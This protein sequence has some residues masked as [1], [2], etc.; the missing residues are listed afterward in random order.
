MPTNQQ[1]FNTARAHYEAGRF[2][3]AREVCLT[4][5]KQIPAYGPVFFML[6]Y[7]ERRLKNYGG[8]VDAFARAMKIG[9]EDPQALYQMGCA[10]HDLGNLDEAMRWYRMALAQQPGW[11]EATSSL[12]DALVFASKRKAVECQRAAL[13][14]NPQLTGA[15]LGLAALL[16][17]RKD[18]DESRRHLE[19]ALAQNPELAATHYHLAVLDWLSG[20]DAAAADA[21][22]QLPAHLADSLDYMRANRTPRTRFFGAAPDVLE[23][24]LGKAGNEGLYLE[25]GVGFGNSLRFLAA[26]TDRR[27]HGFDSFEGVDAARAGTP[28]PGASLIEVPDNVTLHKGRFSETLP[29]FARDNS[30]P[31]A[32]AHVDCIGHASA[33]DVFDALGERF[34]AGTVLVIDRHVGGD[35][36]RQQGVK[37]FGE[38]VTRRCVSYEY[39]AFGIF[40]NQAVVRVL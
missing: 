14:L 37:A 21:A 39:L 33:R 26:R 34:V 23:F 27:I 17:D 16:F 12:G 19:T 8:S 18:P 5:L 11:A 32:F 6:G 29:A 25:F 13:R 36:W 24:A 10:W 7:C 40:S 4:L 20:G 22:K 35:G 15:A 3:R 9:G 28:A 1:L 38:F 30:G 2:E 31:V